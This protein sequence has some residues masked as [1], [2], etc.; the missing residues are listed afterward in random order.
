MSEIRAEQELVRL[1]AWFLPFRSCLVAFSSGVDS[2]LVALAARMALGERALA[3]TS[4]SPAFPERELDEARKIASE[5]GIKLREVHQND[6]ETFGY[7]ENNV[8]RCYFCRNNLGKAIQPLLRE[9]AIDVW[10]DGT[11]IDDL[12]TPRPG[13]KALREAGFRSP[14]VELG[15]GKSA[16]REM[17]RIARLSNY[18]K[19]SE[20]CL[21]S[22]IAFGQQIDLR[23]LKLVDEAENIVRKFTRAT[24]VRV[25]TIGNKALI[26]VDTDS[27]SK[28]NAAFSEISRDLKELG[29]SAVELDP[30]GYARGSMLSLFVNEKL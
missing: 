23:T 13:I 25:R 9:E 7:V 20:A 12:S 16:V 8:S 3:V 28:A 1:I 2:T 17:A 14:L 19:P 6:L 5:I 4:I 18:A 22:R 29:Y 11:Q 26:Q 30:K 21:S 15:L 24:I 27:I 10:V